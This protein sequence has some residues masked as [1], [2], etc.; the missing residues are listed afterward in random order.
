[1]QMMRSLMLFGDL[2]ENKMIIQVRAFAYFRDILG[3]DLRVELGKAPRS[4]RL[5]GLKAKIVWFR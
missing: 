1:M 5:F 4:R 2:I 3:R